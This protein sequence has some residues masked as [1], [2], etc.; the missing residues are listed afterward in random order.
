MAD[1]DL[2]PTEEMASNAARGL[3]LREKHGRGGTAVGVARA[4]DIKN[5]KNLSP[6]TVRRMHSF[7]SRHAGNEAGGEDDAGYISFLLWG[8]AAGRSW[9]KRKSAQLDKDE[10]AMSDTRKEIMERLGMAAHPGAKAK[11]G[12]MRGIGDWAVSFTN[13]I[14][15]RLPELRKLARDLKA[16]IKVS[17]PS[18]NGY[19]SGT[20]TRKYGSSEAPDLMASGKVKSMIQSLGGQLDSRL[21]GFSRPGAKAK[22]AAPRWEDFFPSEGKGLLTEAE[23]LQRKIADKSR[24]L[25]ETTRSLQIAVSTLKTALQSQD[26]AAYTRARQMIYNADR[27][28]SSFSRPGAKA[29]FGVSVG[30]RVR[31]ALAVKGGAGIVGTVTKIADDYVYITADASASDK[32]GAKTYKVPMRLVT[33]AS[34]PGAKAK[35]AVN[36]KIEKEPGDPTEWFVYANGMNVGTITQ[37]LERFASATSRARG[38]KVEGYG[39]DIETD[40]VYSE[41][42]P[43]ER[44]LNARAALKAATDYAIRAASKVQASRP[45]AKAR[46]A[47]TDACWQGYEAVGTKQKD[48][49]TVPNCVPKNK[50]AI[51]E[52]EKVSASDDAVSRKIRKLMDEG[53]P[54]KQA[55]AIAL[56]LERR[57][58]L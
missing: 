58:E 26:A 37:L 10:N 13:I 15:E 8:G 54:Q 9:A 55:V 32:Y 39:V 52:G 17:S 57:G 19:V 16:S 1:I 18:P 36:I 53:K 42:F 11:M 2:T 40:R 7:F 49:K 25:F 29:K 38:T 4:R 24:E 43:V 21:A 5:R 30:D 28:R 20:I 46:H 14:V 44:Y 27:A 33:K 47:L 23:N 22:M 56:D 31:G 3:E 34:R 50:N 51:R 12:G 35:F 41:Y 45:G 48:G 6:D